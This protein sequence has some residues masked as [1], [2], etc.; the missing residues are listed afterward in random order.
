[1]KS[2]CS[3]ETMRLPGSRPEDGLPASIY[4]LASLH[5]CQLKLQIRTI[6]SLHSC[7]LKLPI[8]TIASLNSCQLKVQIY[9]IASLH[10][11][12]LEH[13]INNTVIASLHGHY[14]RMFFAWWAEFS[15]IFFSTLFMNHGFKFSRCVYS[16]YEFFLSYLRLIFLLLD[17]F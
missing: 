5:S 16:R 17:I 13:Q 2:T 14:W 1:M 15:P 4:N 9:T 7:Q 3:C 8:Y 11:Y 10:S 12:Q 6:A